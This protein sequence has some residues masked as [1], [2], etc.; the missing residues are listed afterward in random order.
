MTTSRRGLLGIFSVLLLGLLIVVSLLH[1]RPAQAAGPSVS[2]WLTT[3]FGSQCE[4]YRHVAIRRNL[5]DRSGQARVQ[6]FH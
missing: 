6:R 1:A 2:T 5:L 3:T 4:L